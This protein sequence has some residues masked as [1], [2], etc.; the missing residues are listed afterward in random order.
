M[1]SENGVIVEDEKRVIEITIEEE[2]VLNLSKDDQNADNDVHTVNAVS[3]PVLKAEHINCATVTVKA[4]AT[5]PAS[6]SSKVFKEPGNLSQKNI[7]STKDKPSSKVATS[8]S[9]KQKPILSQNLSFPAKIVCADRMKK[10]TNGYLLKAKVKHSQGN[11]DNPESPFHH[12]SKFL[13]SGLNSKEA[14]QQTSSIKHS[15]SKSSGSSISVTGFPPFQEYLSIND[16][17]QP[18]QTALSSKGDDDAQSTTSSTSRRKSSGSKLPFRLDER[19]EKRK[20]FFTKLEERIQAKEEEKTNL[21]AKSKENQEA[22]IRTLRKSL[23]FKATPMP[24]FYKEPPPK[25]ELKKIPTTRAIS[26]KLGRNK[27]SSTANSTSEGEKSCSSPSLRL[28]DNNLTKVA[29]GN[30]DVAS[31][32][33]LGKSQTRLQPN[34][35]AITETEEELFESQTKAT[36]ESQSQKA[37][38]GENEESHVQSANHFQPEMVT[39]GDCQTNTAVNN[40]LVLNSPAPEIILHEAS[41]GV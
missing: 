41:V 16:N 11:G 18:L 39:D 32:R 22:E 35:T 36:G 34:E 3:T 21:Q 31:K 12:P 30:R 37:S 13:H 9:H 7:K 25:V 1:E 5:A 2:P 33:A 19:A 14:I 15:M 6:K 26:P 17:P 10:S 24:C 29:K 4:S 28:K 40:A 8:S 23:T 20:E 27:C 38:T